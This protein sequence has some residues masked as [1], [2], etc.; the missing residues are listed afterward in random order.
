MLVPFAACRLVVFAS[1]RR[2]GKAENAPSRSER[3][4]NGDTE[5]GSSPPESSNRWIVTG[6]IACF[7]V[8]AS[9]FPSLPPGVRN[10]DNR[11]KLQVAMNILRG[12]GPVLTKHTP[13]DAQYVLRG[14]DGNYYAGYPPAA[15]VLQFIT[16]AVAA[17]GAGVAEGVSALVLLG[18]VAWALV[19]WA[20]RSGASPPAA[21][22]GAVLVCF[23]TALWPSAAH[24]YD[25]LI[26]VLAL[27]LVA[28]AGA[29]GER[30]TA[31]LW[32]GLAVGIAFATRFGS[33]LLAIPA[34]L[35]V[36][37]QQPRARRDVVRRGV[38]FAAGCAPGIA[39]VLWFNWYRFG[40]PFVAYKPT[41][42]GTAEQLTVRWF[43]PSHWEAIAGLTISPGK[44]ILWYG[45]P[46]IGVLVLIV[47]LARRYRREYAA[48]AAYALACLLFFGTFIYWHGE[49]GW[50]PRY[51][52][53]LYIA[54][55]PLAWWC[56]EWT[57][58][59]GIAAK[60]AAATVLSLLLAVQAAPVIGYPIETHL[61]TTVSR[62]S[63]EGRTV[64]WPITRPPV[65]ADNDVLYFRLENSQLASLARKFVALLPD[66][67]RGAN[68]RTALLKAMMVPA[69]SLLFV[70]ALALYR[71][72]RAVRAGVAAPAGQG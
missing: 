8:I 36:A 66:A 17:A 47:P 67:V 57:K 53:P 6:A 59:H 12:A 23:G 63:M 50:G 22:A 32:A 39:T 4:V 15:Y 34:A 54:A 5:T 25:V 19:G 27:A 64:T 41:V 13:D 18:L 10:W 49:W 61:S 68:L 55:A 24:G 38:A 21:A 42:H 69:L 62:L 29:G 30:R 2:R 20:R 35:L 65:P 14:S 51:V 16:L 43:S 58:A 71:R 48:F 31:W 60:I 26:E 3:R 40:S 44:G 45:P 7:V 33:A 28:W 70:F 1:R 72:G 9:A 56:W 46:L 37:T 52:A 11:V